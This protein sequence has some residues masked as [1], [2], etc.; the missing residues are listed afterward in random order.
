MSTGEYAHQRRFP[1]TVFDHNRAAQQLIYV[2]IDSQALHFQDP[3]SKMYVR[4]IL[5]ISKHK[6]K[7]LLGQVRSWAIAFI[8]LA[9]TPAAS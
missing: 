2:P 3:Y 8:I 5:C 4:Y 7:T 1:T 6:K 9:P